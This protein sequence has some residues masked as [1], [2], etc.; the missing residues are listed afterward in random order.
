MVETTSRYTRSVEGFD[1]IDLRLLRLLAEDARLSQRALGRKLDMSAPAVGERIAR[2][3]RN[4]VIRTYTVDV[5]WAKLE[6]PMVAFIHV[7]SV[8]GADQRG[9]LVRLRE[10]PSVQTVDVV[11]GS[12]D[13]A[14][15]LRV[16]DHAHLRE[17]LF[18]EVLPLTEVQ[19]TETLI[20]LESMPYK[21]FSAHML[22]ELLGEE[23]TEA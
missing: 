3:E 23:L 20:S 15:Q 11:T 19:R 16:R 8:Q 1:D 12:S 7:V 14:V 18:D 5:D 4:G 9:L 2:L 6:R 17:I 22:T 13:L 10:L 21:N